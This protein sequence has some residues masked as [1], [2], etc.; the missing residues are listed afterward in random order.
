MGYESLKYLSLSFLICKVGVR[1]VPIP[2]GLG[3]MAY[4]LWTLE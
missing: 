1:R 4:E 3:E 2:Q